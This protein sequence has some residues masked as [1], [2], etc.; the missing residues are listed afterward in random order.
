M[1]KRTIQISDEDGK[2][3]QVVISIGYI[4][5][6]I[7]TWR[8][9][10]NGFIR[11]K[12][13]KVDYSNAGADY[14][15]KN[16]SQPTV[17]HVWLYESPQSNVTGLRLNDYVHW[18]GFNDQ[19]MGY[20]WQPWVLDFKPYRISWCWVGAGSEKTIICQLKDDALGSW[21]LVKIA[22]SLP[23]AGE[24]QRIFPGH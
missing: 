13:G 9:L 10:E 20:L 12:Q 7:E 11:Y 8:S 2:S 17:R 18:S 21:S 1:S 23:R 16:Y 3:F 14:T 24:I 22:E 15:K 4:A 19:G 5:G 6:S